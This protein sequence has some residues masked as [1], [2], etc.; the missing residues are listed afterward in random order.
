MGKPLKALQFSLCGF[1]QASVTK[2]VIK[3][4][5]NCQ[6][7]CVSTYHKPIK[8]QASDD[9]TFQHIDPTIHSRGMNIKLSS[10]VAE[11]KIS[12]VPVV[13]KVAEID[14]NFLNC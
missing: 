8:P 13:I 14:Y 10:C 3:Y 6:D 9:K 5:E 12:W 7:Q 11:L 2:E 4:S 1:L